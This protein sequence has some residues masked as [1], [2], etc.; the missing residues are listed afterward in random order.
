M[1]NLPPFV[2]RIG[3]V[4][5]P[6]KVGGKERRPAE[7]PFR[8]RPTAVAFIREVGGFCFISPSENS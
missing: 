8:R 7:N 3:K 4:F 5:A 2:C 1:Q 6:S